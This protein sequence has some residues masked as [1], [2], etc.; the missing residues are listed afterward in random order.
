MS[1]V[2][3]VFLLGHLGGFLAAYL[4][5]TFVP[6]ILASRFDLLH[7]PPL[8]LGA[9]PRGFAK[10]RS[11]QDI[12]IASP[13]RDLRVTISLA[14]TFSVPFNR[15]VTCPLSAPPLKAALA[16]MTGLTPSA[17]CTT[18]ATKSSCHQS[19]KRAREQGRPF[20][21]KASIAHFWPWPRQKPKQND[22]NAEAAQTQ[23][24]A[25]NC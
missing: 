1:L 8:L 23:A 6:C 21:S 12:E 11:V 3:L 22:A 10:C 19:F 4:C 25:R 13:Y 16:A 15:L 20:V 2:L 5:W 18:L 24:R 14:I 7:L 9:L 17:G